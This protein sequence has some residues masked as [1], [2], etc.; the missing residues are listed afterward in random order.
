MPILTAIAGRGI[1]Q[2]LLTATQGEHC[3]SVAFAAEIPRVFRSLPSYR[4]IGTNRG[5][6]RVFWFC[7]N[8]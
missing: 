6:L 5:G 3:E 7:S 4:T 8:L 1:Q 2:L